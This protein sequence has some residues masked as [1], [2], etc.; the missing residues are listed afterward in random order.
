MREGTRQHHYAVY[1]SWNEEDRHED[2]PADMANGRNLIEVAE[3]KNDEGAED[4]AAGQPAWRMF[5]QWVLARGNNVA[6]S[7][8]MTAS[9]APLASEKIKVPQ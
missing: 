2:L 9:H 4:Q 8:L 5:S 1:Q 3:S 7:G 6:V